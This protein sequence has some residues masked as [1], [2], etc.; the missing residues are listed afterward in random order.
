MIQKISRLNIDEN[1][2]LKDKLLEMISLHAR[3]LLKTSFSDISNF[4]QLNIYY[5]FLSK[6]LNLKQYYDELKE[7]TTEIEYILQERINREDKK[8]MHRMEMILAI[9]LLPQIIF[10]FLSVLG[11]FFQVK[12]QHQLIDILF[13]NDGVVNSLVLIIML[14]L[15]P[16]LFL[17]WLIV[18]ESFKKDK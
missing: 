3:I 13:Q 1:N 18:K 8:R 2:G 4:T 7:K 11:D 9:L 15:V 14:S 10:A 6:N 5:A 16:T 12:T 17:L